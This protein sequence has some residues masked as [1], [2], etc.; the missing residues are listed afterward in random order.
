MTGDSERKV[1]LG[2]KQKGISP[3]LEIKRILS[4]RE[5]NYRQKMYGE[6]CQNCREFIPSPIQGCEG[7]YNCKYMGVNKDFYAFVQPEYRCIRCKK[8]L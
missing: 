1:M 8:K 7:K 5:A 4:Y 3:Y 2:A 6:I